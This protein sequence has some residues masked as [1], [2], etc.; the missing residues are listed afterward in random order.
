MINPIDPHSTKNP[1]IIRFVDVGG[2]S[3]LDLLKELK[4]NSISLNQLAEQLFES[5]HFTTSK[6]RVRVA[7]I[8]ITVE[9]LGFHHGAN[10]PDIYSKADDLGFRLCPLELAPNFRLQYLNQLEGHCDEMLQQGQAPAG[11]I[12]IASMQQEDANS[13]Q[14][15]YLRNIKGHLWLRGYR[16]SLDHVWKANDHFFFMTQ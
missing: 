2:L 12:T 14:G 5:S 13:P 6:I 1:G 7:T 3:K 10:I 15:F 16:C 8:E 9:E 4:K 11:S